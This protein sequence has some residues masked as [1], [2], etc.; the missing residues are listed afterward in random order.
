MSGIGAAQAAS[1]ALNELGIDQASPIDP[2]TAI[3]QAGLVLSFK[4]LKDLLGVILPGEVSGVLIN[5]ARPPSLQRYTAAHELG[6]WFLHQQ[7]LRLDTDAMIAGHDQDSRELE[8]QTFAAHF[9]MPLELLYSAA[10]RYGIRRRAE[11]HPEQVYQAARDMHVSY[12]AAA[13]QLANTRVISAANRNELLRIRP[14]AIK[15]KLADGLSPPDPRG[16]VWMLDSPEPRTDVEAFVGDAIVLRLIEHPS[17]G[18]RWFTESTLESATVHEFRPAPR[19]F[20]GRR[21][22]EDVDTDH[23]AE[24]ISLPPARATSEVVTLLRDDLAE[25]TY[26]P[27]V[28]NVGGPVVRLIA[29]GAAAPGQESVRLRQVRPFRTDSVMSKVELSTRVRG[30]PDVEFRE[31]LIA[32]FRRGETRTGAWGTDAGR[33]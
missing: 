7:V 9:L 32:E 29:F 5:S 11:A 13:R 17:S 16:D 21:A 10:G 19:G 18:Y 1:D 20:E 3:E 31:R 23:V 24:V 28:T 26:E 2:F 22:F 6:H 12:E 25:A 30:A 15:R 27:N 33:H 4:P 14:A 8:A